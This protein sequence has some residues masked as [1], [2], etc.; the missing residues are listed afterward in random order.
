MSQSED[1]ADR[2]GERLTAWMQDDARRPVE[3][4]SLA[5]EVRRRSMRA[6]RRRI[7]TTIATCAAAVAVA[8]GVVV[9]TSMTGVEGEAVEVS[10]RINVE[11]PE[12]TFLSCKTKPVPPGY[13]VNSV[14]SA[15]MFV[16]EGWLFD[17]TESEYTYAFSPTIP[18][19]T[20]SLASQPIDVEPNLKEL[21]SEVI[22]MYAAR[23]AVGV[24][25]APDVRLYDV[26]VN[27]VDFGGAEWAYRRDLRFSV[28]GGHM[29][30]A[31]MLY[32]ERGIGQYALRASTLD[33]DWGAFSPILQV[34]ID[35]ARP[36]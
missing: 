21:T 25:A 12:R 15:S 9:T 16:P 27:R 2:I 19:R 30:R 22:T 8:C 33:S 34:A 29:I 23:S 11:S 31:M 20:L 5:A 1:D 7:T 24:G 3:L 14:E 17:G 36:C 13:R 35:G 4:A 10:A 32:W 28:D 18:R 26:T 6:R